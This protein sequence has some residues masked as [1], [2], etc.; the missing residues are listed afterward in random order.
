MKLL[1]NLLGDK[2]ILI[3][4]GVVIN[5]KYIANLHD[6]QD[7]EGLRA[8]NKI[9]RSHIDYHKQI[10]KVKLAVQVFSSSVAKGLIASMKSILGIGNELLG[11]NPK[12]NYFLTY[13]TSQDHLEL[14]FSCLH[15]R[16]G[17]NN[18]PSAYQ[19]RSAIRDVLVA[20]LEVITTGRM[21]GSYKN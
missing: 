9:G 12:L 5:W 10:M 1:R 11:P 6:L 14:F 15:S 13:K 20:K 3:N 4:N 16:G 2:K 17:F 8:A 19:L 21:G 7:K 18:N